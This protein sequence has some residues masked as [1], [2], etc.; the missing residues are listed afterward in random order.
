MFPKPTAFLRSLF[1]VGSQRTCGSR[2][3]AGTCVFDDVSWTNILDGK[4]EGRGVTKTKLV[5]YEIFRMVHL[6]GLRSPA[7]PISLPSN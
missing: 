4:M 7:I 6:D 5:T 2:P 3:S 1:L